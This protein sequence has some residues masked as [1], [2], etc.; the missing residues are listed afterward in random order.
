MSKWQRH[1]IF[2]RFLSLLKSVTLLGNPM[3]TN[4][5]SPQ[6]IIT[7][8]MLTQTALVHCLTEHQHSLQ[9]DAVHGKFRK[10]VSF[11][12]WIETRSRFSAQS[13]GHLVA[14]RC[15]MDGQKPFDAPNKDLNKANTCPPFTM[16]LKIKPNRYLKGKSYY[17]YTVQSRIELS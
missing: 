8:S 4:T 3:T 15:P 11:C 2:P 10:I 5:V 12:L 17:C 13:A 9:I 7:K 14:C 6:Q 1:I 16:R